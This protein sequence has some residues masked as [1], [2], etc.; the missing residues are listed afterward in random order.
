MKEI[1]RGAFA[2]VCL[3]KDESLLGRRVVVKNLQTSGADRWVLRKFQPE[4]EALVPIDHSGVDS[5]LDAR[6]TEDG[7]PFLVMQYVDGMTLRSVIQPGG[8]PA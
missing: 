5:A 8:A 4:K 3:A 1:G 2:A 6:S 7:A